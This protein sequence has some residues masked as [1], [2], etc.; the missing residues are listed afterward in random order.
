MIIAIDGPA[1]AGKGTIASYL[2]TNFN[3]AYLDTGLLYRALARLVIDEKIDPADTVS[4]ANIA[5]TLTVKDVEKGHLRGEAVAAVA[6]RVAVVEEVRHILNSLQQSFCRAVA[7]PWQGAVLDGRDIGTIIWPDAECKLFIT[8]RPEVRNQRRLCETGDNRECEENMARYMAE[9]DNRDTFRK[10][11]PLTP[12][13]DA[14]IIDTSDLS[15]KDACSKAEQYV[16]QRCGI[17]TI[18][19]GTQAGLKK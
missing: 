7:P 2:A 18:G 4:L 15:V 5:C 13:S 19:H 16:I 11:A 14:C 12:A 17:N 8:A 6:S 9:R 1:G 10:I 3:L